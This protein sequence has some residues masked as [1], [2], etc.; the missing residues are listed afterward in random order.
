MA[1]PACR[2]RTGRPRSPS[3]PNRPRRARR[4]LSLCAAKMAALH[5]GGH[6]GKC[7]QCGNVASCQCCQFPIGYWPLELYIGNTG[8]ILTAPPRG[9]GRSGGVRMTALPSSLNAIPS[10]AKSPVG[11]RSLLQ[12]FSSYGF[13]NV[14]LKVAF[15]TEEASFGHTQFP[16]SHLGSHQF[17]GTKEIR[18]LKQ[19]VGFGMYIHN[20]FSL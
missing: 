1:R 3:G 4:P 19:P 5:T 14:P 15:L 8:N 7:C 10:S 6:S 18:C 16:N 12:H 2:S 11:T 9:G 13:Q 20:E 17:Y